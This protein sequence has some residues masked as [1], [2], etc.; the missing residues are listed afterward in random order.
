MNMKG[1][2]L[3]AA[4]GLLFLFGACEKDIAEG[5]GKGKKVEIFLSTDITNYHAGGDVT[6]N[7]GLR[8]PESRTIYINDS[9]Y[10]Q[11]TLVPDE[12]ELRV[13]VTFTDGQ[14]IRFVAF[15]AGTQAEVD[16]KV[17]S[18]STSAGKFIPDT[19]PLGVDPDGATVYRFVAY[20]YFGETGIAP[21][22]SSIDP[23]HELVWG[24]TATDQTITDTEV[25]RTVSISMTHK[26]ARVKVNVQSTGISGANITA[27]SGVEIDGGQLAGLT[28]FDGSIG[29]SGTAAQGIN[30][31][32]PLPAENDISSSYRTVKPMAAGSLKVKIG[33]VSVTG[34]PA[35]ANQEV[36]FSSAL[37]AATSYTLLVEL[38]RKAP[39][40]YSNIVWTGTKLTFATT[41]AETATIPQESGGVYFK[42]GSLVALGMLD[43]YTEGQY[44]SGSILF[45]STGY[46]YYTYPN[47]PYANETAAPFNNMEVEDDFATYNGNTGFNASTGKGDI[48][49]YISSQGWVS[50]NWRMPTSGDF[51]SL[52]TMV[53]STGGV[54]GGISS[55][56][57]SN[58]YGDYAYGYYQPHGMQYAANIFLP[59][60]GH[61]DRASY[62]LFSV[63]YFA[64]VWTA[65]SGAPT[66]MTILHSE[67]AHA[68]MVNPFPSLSVGITA[69]VRTF[70]RAVRCIKN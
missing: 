15:N 4:M 30:I 67:G 2:Y 57:G 6:R 26:F 29:W 11:T 64:S 23:V 41:L 50:G 49:R 63:E 70:A 53:G 58:A 1:K 55:P 31:T 3:V 21:A 59:Y 66:Y 54:S 16:S 36:E 33:N 38:K 22:V 20:S 52:P 7:L 43:S 62:S 28:A 65:E 40:A 19:D 56:V 8:E 13:P 60:A 44:P 12:A 45:S 14:K 35:F 68:Y 48:C 5:F 24:K 25:S 10:L 51:G 17:Y 18:W 32:V 69:H 37:A 42:W 47:I 27:L 9:I 61:W 46:Y 34:S 39:F